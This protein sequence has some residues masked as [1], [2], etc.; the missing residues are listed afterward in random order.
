MLP[1]IGLI[2]LGHVGSATQVG[3]FAAASRIPTVLYAIPG[4]V[5]SAW[6][7]QLFQA[8]SADP[9]RHFR[10]CLSQLKIN[11]ILGFG[12]SLPI[13]LNSRLVI[14]TLLGTAWEEPT[15]TILS[16]LC[17][18]VML[19]SITL[20]LADALTTQGLQNR[21]AVIYS[22]AVAIGSVLFFQFG[23][24]GGALGAAAAALLTQTLLSAAL[25]VVNPSGLSL[26][27]ASGRHLL[28]PMVFG[29]CSVVAMRLVLPV[30]YASAA[31]TAFV[32]FTVAALVDRELRTG[33]TR[34]VSVI[35]ER[36]RDALANA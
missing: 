16:W 23:S 9:A 13:A 14:R 36:W 34:L 4:C 31:L 26:L 22:V 5:A 6:Y 11:G 3:Y 8:G 35:Q 25:V 7:P 12:L 2:V 21:R 29:S 33:V 1:Q 27:A 15:A 17:W 10:L 24:N 32:F 30:T 19:N 20:P 18:T 28:V